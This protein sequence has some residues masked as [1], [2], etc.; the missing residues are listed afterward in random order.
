MYFLLIVFSRYQFSMNRTNISEDTCHISEMLSKFT[1]VEHLDGPVYQCDECN[2]KRRE[3]SGKPVIRTEA[4]KR[5]LVTKLPHIL[6][7]HL[8]RFR[9]NC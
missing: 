4:T 2:S 6:R 1:E 5:L 9:Y 3:A 8:K 7:L